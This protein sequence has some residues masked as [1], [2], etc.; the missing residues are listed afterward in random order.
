MINRLALKIIYIAY[1]QALDTKTKRALHAFGSQY[2]QIQFVNV[3]FYGY[4]GL[5][6]VFT[7]LE[8]MKCNSSFSSLQ[9]YQTVNFVIQLYLLIL[10]KV[11]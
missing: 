7:S 6:V 5:Q 8:K 11:D 1:F 2:C 4:N 9:C 10:S 3:C